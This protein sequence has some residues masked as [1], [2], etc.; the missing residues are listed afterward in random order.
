MQH[1]TAGN[2]AA[3]TSHGGRPAMSGAFVITVQ[4]VLIAFMF[5]MLVINNDDHGGH[6]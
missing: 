2:A 3:R 6:A 5:V 4:L 1:A